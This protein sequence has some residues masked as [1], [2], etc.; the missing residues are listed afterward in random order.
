MESLTTEV[1][2]NITTSVVLLVSHKVA[3]LKSH[4]S[5]GSLAFSV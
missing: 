5:N 4:Q 1:A 3:R 2:Y